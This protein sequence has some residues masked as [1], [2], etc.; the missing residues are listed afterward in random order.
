MW[1]VTDTLRETCADGTR[2]Y[3]SRRRLVRKW[4]LIYLFIR[5]FKKLNS[6]EAQIMTRSAVLN[7]CVLCSEVCITV[8]KVS[9]D[10]LMQKQRWEAYK[11]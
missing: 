2:A 1:I 6:N 4:E 5:I 3:M 7:F 10:T 11:S 9:K 8:G